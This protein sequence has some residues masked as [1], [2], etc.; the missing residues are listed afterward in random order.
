[1]YLI[2]SRRFQQDLYTTNNDK[3]F[4][5]LDSW[6]KKISR[7]NLNNEPKFETAYTGL[8]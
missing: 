3:S 8:K 7:K 1:M 6:L 2:F 4:N 5:F